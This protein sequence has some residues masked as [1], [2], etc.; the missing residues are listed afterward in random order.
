LQNSQIAI[1]D[2]RE[3]EPGLPVDDIF[4][5]PIV[6][7]TT[8]H[9]SVFAKGMWPVVAFR[10]LE[11]DLLKP[12]FYFIEDSFTG[13]YQKYRS[14]DGQMVPSTREECDGLDRVE[15]WESFHVEEWL[16]GYYAKS[17]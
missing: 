5:A 16:R 7:K 2:F 1:Y 11:A 13:K 9:K 15:V 17:S 3:S 14:T 10:P 4:C 8:V 6:K 12:V